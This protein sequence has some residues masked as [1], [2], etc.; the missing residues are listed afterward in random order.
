[1]T[2]GERERERE[3]HREVLHFGIEGQVQV[4]RSANLYVN[5]HVHT[6]K[7]RP[8]LEH[9]QLLGMELNPSDVCR[10]PLL[11]NT[12]FTSDVSVL[13]TH[14]NNRLS[15]FSRPPADPWGDQQM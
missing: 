8:G 4:H 7:W 3:R 15:V 13:I 5:F 11:I 14:K 6:S 10:L 1:M 2:E 12:G 9:K